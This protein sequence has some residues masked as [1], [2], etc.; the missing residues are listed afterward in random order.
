MS[1]YGG[2]ARRFAAALV[3]A[4]TLIASQLTAHA[5]TPPAPTFVAVTTVHGS[6][7]FR[8]VMKTDGW[9]Y[10]SNVWTLDV[11]AVAPPTG[12]TTITSSWRSPVLRAAAR[13]T[14]F[15]ST[16]AVAHQ[17]VSDDSISVLQNARLC[18]SAGKCSPMIRF[19]ESSVRQVYEVGGVTVTTAPNGKGF[20]MKAGSRAVSGFVEWEFTLSQTQT[21]ET[22]TAVTIAYGSGA[23]AHAPK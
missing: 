13:T 2:M 15:A 14:F 3:V 7:F 22:E 12:T 23:A 18:R 1:N 21:D 16:A 10:Q 9:I 6:P 5:A 11:R 4:A 17:G 20:V 19:D 8:P